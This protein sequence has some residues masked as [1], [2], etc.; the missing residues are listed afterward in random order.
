MA[1]DYFDI[2]CYYS[3]VLLAKGKSIIYSDSEPKISVI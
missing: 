1:E 3:I 2:C